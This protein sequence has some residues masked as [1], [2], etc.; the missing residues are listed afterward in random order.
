MQ[1]NHILAAGS[2]MQLI[3]ILGDDRQLGHMAGKLS[4]SEYAHRLAAPGQPSGGATRTISSVA[5]RRLGML[6][7]WRAARDRSAPTVH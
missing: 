6:G 3:D 7:W 1:M 2:L 5:L 4:D